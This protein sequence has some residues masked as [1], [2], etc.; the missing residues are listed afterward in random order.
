MPAFGNALTDEQ[1]IALAAYLRHS[2][3]DAP[4]WPNLARSVRES[5]AAL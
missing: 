4:P 5:R 2:A 3:A 1:L